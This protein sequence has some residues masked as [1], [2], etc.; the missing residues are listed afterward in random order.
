MTALFATLFVLHNAS[1]CAGKSYQNIE[2]CHMHTAALHHTAFPRHRA[3]AQQV[4]S[5]RL[6]H[7]NGFHTMVR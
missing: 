2:L 1:L 6:C 5:I 4:C 7:T 3:E